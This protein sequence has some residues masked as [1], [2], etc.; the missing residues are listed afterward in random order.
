[1]EQHEQHQQ[2]MPPISSNNNES[3]S[4]GITVDFHHSAND[5]T[6]GVRPIEDNIA[7]VD[8]VRGEKEDI[9]EEPASIEHVMPPSDENIENDLT[10]TLPGGWKAIVDTDTGKVLYYQNTGMNVVSFSLPAACEEEAGKVVE[11]N[12]RITEEEETHQ[13]KEILS[14]MNDDNNSSHNGE[15]EEDIITV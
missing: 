7:R 11:E 9:D 3:L 14:N 5:K 6:S 13:D 10:S 12:N 2:Q 1:M 15:S 4:R 8:E